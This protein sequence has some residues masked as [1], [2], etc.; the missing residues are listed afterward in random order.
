MV[1]TL[2]NDLRKMFGD[3]HIYL[4]TI[5]LGLMYSFAYMQLD[6]ESLY[7][8][9]LAT[10]YVTITG[11][12]I[13]LLCFLISVV[14]GSFLYCT[15]EKYGY[16]NFEI[17]RVGVDIYTSSK[18]ITSV[19]GGFFTNFVGTILNCCAVFFIIFIKFGHVNLG[20]WMK[21][22]NMIWEIIMH[23]L[24]C[25]LLSALGF[26]VT[27]FISNYYIGMTVPILAYYAILTI[28]LWIPIPSKYKIQ[29]VFLGVD[30]IQSGYLSFFAFAMLYLICFLIFF[31]II[32]RR[33]IQRRIEH[34]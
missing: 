16:L 7:A 27:T 3:Y 22:E 8:D 6:A 10:A 13:V 4:C 31:F 33:R 12:E 5:L 18:L 34:A 14:G 2:V 32:A 30:A 15:E 19:V 20:T 23:S 29:N 26:V 28:S 17:Q 24:L 21:L 11:R 9:T 1:K 25:G